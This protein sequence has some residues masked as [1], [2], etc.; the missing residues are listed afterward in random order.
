MSI[1][2]DH[3]GGIPTAQHETVT[4]RSRKGRTTFKVT[5]HVRQTA[6]S[7]DT[8]S[9]D[10]VIAAINADM[11]NRARAATRQTLG[12]DEV[13]LVRQADAILRDAGMLDDVKLTDRPWLS[14]KRGQIAPMVYG[15][16]AYRGMSDWRTPDPD[17][18]C[19]AHD[20][21][22]HEC[23]CTV[24]LDATIA[25]CALQ[26]DHQRDETDAADVEEIRR[27][28]ETDT[29]NVRTAIRRAAWTLD[30]ARYGT[31]YR[32]TP[33]DRTGYGTDTTVAD[34]HPTRAIV[35]RRRRA[36]PTGVVEIGSRT[37]R[38]GRVI[39]IYGRSSPYQPITIDGT[40]TDRGKVYRLLSWSDSGYWIGNGP[41]TVTPR[42]RNQTA[43]ARKRSAR[44]T[45]ERTAARI[46]A[47]QAPVTDA[48]TAILMALRTNPRES[49]TLNGVTVSRD[50]LGYVVIE[51]PDRTTTRH[52]RRTAAQALATASAQ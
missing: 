28:W 18:W 19:H 32:T 24:Q 50:A 30:G 40:T 23:G 4:R 9:T 3:L 41:H 1:V 26:R 8:A 21:M 13:S 48:V 14:G 2:Y 35:S 15:G 25:R 37:D 29:D 36:I 46:A 22:A 45:A 12:R 44:Q 6:T 39:P 49:Y 34:A 17:A 42:K 7:G 5:R 27:S 51:R 43:A 33:T 16:R 20:M 31:T 47:E 11:P 52:N 10:P 38:R